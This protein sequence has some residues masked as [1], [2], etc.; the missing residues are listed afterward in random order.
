MTHRIGGEKTRNTWY[1]YLALTLV[2]IGGLNWGLVGAFGFNLV[3]ALT[4]DMAWLANTIYVLVGLA[5]IYM[6]YY[7]VTSEH[8]PRRAGTPAGA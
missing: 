8:Q 7:A 6:I 2:T 3:D 1:D 4:G 5:A